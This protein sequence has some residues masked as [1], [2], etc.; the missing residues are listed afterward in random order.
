MDKSWSQ[1]TKNY[2][3]LTEDY[4]TSKKNFETHT[5]KQGHLSLYYFIISS[6]DRELSIEILT[7]GSRKKQYMAQIKDSVK[8]DCYR[9]AKLY[10]HEDLPGNKDLV[11][12]DVLRNLEC[13]LYRL[14]SLLLLNY[15]YV[16]IVSSLF[17]DVKIMLSNMHLSDVIIN[18]PSR[19]HSLCLIGKIMDLRGTSLSKTTSAEVYDLMKKFNQ[20]ILVWYEQEQKYSDELSKYIGYG[21]LN[22]VIS[23]E[24]FK[25]FLDDDKLSKIMCRSDI[26]V[27]QYR[28][29]LV[30]ILSTLNITESCNVY[31]DLGFKFTDKFN[32]VRSTRCSPIIIN[33]DLRFSEPN[34]LYLDINQ[35]PKTGNVTIYTKINGRNVENIKFNARYCDE[36]INMSIENTIISAWVNNRSL[37]VEE[38]QDFLE[39]NYEDASLLLKKRLIRLKKMKDSKLEII[40]QIESFT[41]D[42]QDETGNLNDLM[43]EMFGDFGNFEEIIIQSL[44]EV[45]PEHDNLELMD[46][47]DFGDFDFL[48]PDTDIFGTKEFSNIIEY[49][50]ETVLWD[51]LIKSLE[52]SY[53]PLNYWTALPEDLEGTVMEEVFELMDFK[54]FV[55]LK[56]TKR[57]TIFRKRSNLNK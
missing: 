42:D 5:G 28:I 40:G 36:K 17:K 7:K 26:V 18:I 24:P 25:I 55:E 14:K 15:N 37:D 22:V 21:I 34:K 30:S 48:L 39:S 29:E 31:A 4:G 3:W 32:I 6:D 38:A 44:N 47:D 1:Y 19:Y 43:D 2:S 51:N 54:Y 41:V 46:L 33:K 57:K 23:G 45:V 49:H 50:Y 13:A 52:D 53:G 27:N 9:D 56:S 10:H 35:N 11:L 20:G 8:N 12:T 16:D